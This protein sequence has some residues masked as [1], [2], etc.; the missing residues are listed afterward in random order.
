MQTHPD[1]PV[2]P[3]EP[4]GGGPGAHR[5][6]RAL[7][8]AVA[9]V[10]RLSVAFGATLVGVAATLAT[11]A[12]TTVPALFLAAGPLTGV[13]VWWWVR[14]LVDRRRGS[15]RPGAR[16]LVGASAAIVALAAVLIPLGDP[17]RPAPAPPGAGGWTMP[18]GARLAYGVVRARP[19]SA[20]RTPVVVLHGGP[21]VPDLAGQLAALRPLSDDGHDVW[22]YA[23]RGS[24]GSSR[25]ADP[26]GYTVDQ[27]VGD[28]EQVRQRIGADQVILVGHS[29]GAFLAA[30]YAV[31]FRHRVARLVVSSPGDLDQDGL[32]GAPQSR[33]DDAARRRVYA[34]LAPPRALLAY[35]LTKVD[36]A[37]AHAFAGDRELDARQDR[38][39]AALQPAMHC[40]GRAA[41]RLHGLG[42]YANHVPENMR[43]SPAQRARDLRMSAVPTLV[44]KG[45]CDYLTWESALRYLDVFPNAQLC[46]LLG[47]GHDVYVDEP[48]RYQNAVRAFLRDTP[49]PGLLAQPRLAP[50]TYQRLPR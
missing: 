10:L 25:L 9:A 31:R 47:A 2:D 42:F 22:A 7:R 6:S 46:Y 36:P 44:V 43:R 33:L 11:A 29:Y 3:A 14:R 24:G 19:G 39:Y 50:A 16:P 8:R 18:D 12:V 23:Q 5:R 17:V 45:Q 28:L 37:A 1:S 20:P 41:P 49:V 27:A 38:V 26:A 13:L 32:G 30:T 48:A 40:P 21:G 15:G 34:L 4:N 35:A